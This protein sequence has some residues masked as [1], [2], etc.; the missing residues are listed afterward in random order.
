MLYMIAG[1]AIFGLTTK[2]ICD[3]FKIP[4]ARSGPGIDEGDMLIIAA[5]LVG[6]G[7]GFGVGTMK[8]F[9]GTYLSW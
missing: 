6:G 7:I 8:F 9:S 5:T 4:Y 3:A 2:F 1:A